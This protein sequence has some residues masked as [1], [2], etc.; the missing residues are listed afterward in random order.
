M[1][2]TFLLPE[3]TLSGGV[4][5]V[6]IYAEHLARRGHDVTVISTPPRPVTAREALRR[7]K[8]W[9]WPTRQPGPSHLDGRPIRHKRLQEHRPIAAQDVPD[10]DVV[11][12]TW[13][14][15]AQW[16]RDLP[17]SKGAKAYLIQH[18][19]RAMYP[20]AAGA[21][22]RE[23]VEET[24]RFPMYRVVVA[25][26]IARLLEENVGPEAARTVPNGV[27]VGQFN[28]L[29]RGKQKRPRVGVMYA[30]VRFKGCDVSLRAFEI[31]RE[32]MPDLELVTFG[33]ERVIEALPLPRGAQF[34]ESP[35]QDRIR[36]IYASCDAWLFAS[37]CE[38][39]GLPILEAMA[40][41]TPVIATPAGAAP[42]LLQERGGVLVPFDEPEAMAE[43]IVRN[44]EMPE[45]EWREMS[46]AAHEIAHQHT[47]DKSVDM[48]EAA[49]YEA[50]GAAIDAG[51]SVVQ[52]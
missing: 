51:R 43:E 49:M 46:D 50:A 25:Q 30:T 38:G 19:E 37:R 45:H 40:C 11:V 12:A 39:F 48:F 3:A 6:A 8:H 47:W 21:A 32:R 17:E 14:E 23:L 9:Q 2:I 5:V 7:V 4:R 20:T 16:V 10:G 52:R 44:A 15:T 33:S 13:W 26:W 27:D 18:D 1:K 31:A 29:P 35:P 41:R 28:A 22:K 24:W 34:S 42:E 36:Q